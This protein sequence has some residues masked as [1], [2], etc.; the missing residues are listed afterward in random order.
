[1][2]IVRRCRFITRWSDCSNT[3][4]NN[5]QFGQGEPN[6]VFQHSLGDPGVAWRSDD[7]SNVTV[8]RLGSVGVA[9]VNPH[10][11]CYV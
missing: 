3:Y 6:K 7:H 11:V 10:P 5:A 1:M 9:R 8:T 2:E 4:R